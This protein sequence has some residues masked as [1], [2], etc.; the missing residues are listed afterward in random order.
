[1]IRRV[2]IPAPEPVSPAPLALNSLIA[3]I[4]YASFW[5]LIYGVGVASFV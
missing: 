3:L 2:H 4:V 5:V 1:M